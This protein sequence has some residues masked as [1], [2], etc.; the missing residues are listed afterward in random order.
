MTHGLPD[1]YRGVD[2]AYQALAEMITRPKYGAAQRAAGNV[3]VA[4]S[5]ETTL[6][7]VSAKGMVYGGLFWL[8]HTA[9]HATSYPRF[10]IDGQLVASYSFGGMIEFG[11]NKPLCSPLVL[12]HYDNA[13][14]KYCAGLTYGYTFETSVTLKYLEVPGGQPTVSYELFYATV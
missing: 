13:A 4:A 8:D 1:F 3:V 5:A 9:T 10:Y 14:F 12:L 11:I 2:I 7:T 6:V